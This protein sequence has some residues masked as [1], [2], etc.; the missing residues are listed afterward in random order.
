MNDFNLTND[1]LNDYL[2]EI[3]KYKILSHEEIVK[4]FI[5]YKKGDLEARKK[6]IE[7]NLRFVVSI[8]KHYSNY[9]VELL[10]LI[11][12]GN[13][14][15]IRAVE[16]Y[17]YKRDK[18]FTTYSYYWIRN[19][20]LR[21]LQYKNK[22]IIIPLYVRKYLLILERYKIQLT[23]KL[24][25]YPTKSELKEYFIKNEKD[26]NITVDE[27]LEFKELNNM[28]SLNEKIIYDEEDELIDF[29][30]SNDDIESKV[31]NN[32]DIS[33]IKKILDGTIESNLTEKE[34]NILIYRY[35][36]NCDAKTLEKTGDAVGLKQERI[37]QIE[38]NALR[39]LR[40]SDKIKN[41]FRK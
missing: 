13:Y 24:N 38:A 12:E 28:I 32:I 33:N 20:I 7:N 41:M 35:G 31:E 4:L 11:E 18:H 19:Y 29:I 22:R 27:L 9:G 3:S 37:R 15:L 39:K 2:N 14:G 8:A 17:D 23:N 34:K 40:R 26:C 6:I 1:Q 10:D 5:K 16:L 21:A 30:R 25:R 36:I